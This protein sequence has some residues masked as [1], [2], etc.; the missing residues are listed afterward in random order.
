M[1]VSKIQAQPSKNSAGC[2]FCISSTPGAPWILFECA[3]N[4]FLW[5]AWNTYLRT[6]WNTYVGFQHVLNMIHC[7]VSWCLLQSPMYCRISLCLLT[8]NVCTKKMH[9]LPFFCVLIVTPE[10]PLNCAF[11]W[12]QISS[13]VYCK[14]ALLYTT[15]AVTWMSL[16]FTQD[17][18][19][20]Y[21]K[22][23]SYTKLV[24]S[25]APH[26]TTW[27][28]VTLHSLNSITAPASPFLCNR[29]ISFSTGVWGVG[30]QNCNCFI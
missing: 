29:S 6:G 25:H 24:Q 26:N 16:L 8:C 1:V 3:G 10:N 27:N 2:I 15:C 23:A 14:C 11:E 7:S 30:L 28:S 19:W 4:T 12:G 22:C 9:L 13:L 18:Q 17:V 20:H 5:N 21:Q